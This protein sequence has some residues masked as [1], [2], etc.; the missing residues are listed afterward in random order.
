MALMQ[1]LAGDGFSQAEMAFLSELFHAADGRLTRTAV[2]MF[3]VG[4]HCNGA[5]NELVYRPDKPAPNGLLSRLLLLG[6]EFNRSL[7]GYG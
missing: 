3:G 5:I 4:K 1:E 7:D 6:R 2:V